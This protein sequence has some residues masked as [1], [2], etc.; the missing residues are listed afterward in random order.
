M[1]QKVINNISELVTKH[2]EN[3]PVNSFLIPKRLRKDVAIVY[4]FARTADDLADE[5]FDPE[6][7][8]LEN[9]NKF[10]EE[11]KLALDGKSI[12]EYFIELNRTIIK[13]SLKREYFF[14]LLSAFKQDVIK[15]RYK[16]FDE[17]EDYCRRSANPVGRIILDLFNIKNSDA[18]KYSDMIC[19][20]LQLTNFY[21]D[22]VIDF[23]K[24]RIYYPEDEMLKFG[25][26][27]KM[28]ELHQFNSN[29]KSL[30][31][32]SVDRTQLL[33]DAGKNILP[34]LSGRF[35]LEIKWTIA[36]GEKIL[37]K[38]RKNDFN[39]F[40]ERPFLSKLDYFFILLK[41]IFNNA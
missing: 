2:Y 14:D 3:F 26:T 7:K 28:F 18:I 39:V 23:M 24:G 17:L 11:L 20:A 27:E 29:I 21:Q 30:V 8:R 32:N 36:G 33:F 41:S 22:T 9:L 19:T 13:H 38:I 40:F 31:K 1:N 6:E 12:N 35:K 15:K 37:Q 25:V 34:F 4:W 10:E 5:G 16:T